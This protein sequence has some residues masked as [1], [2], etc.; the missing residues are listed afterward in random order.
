MTNEIF[1]NIKPVSC[2]ACQDKPSNVQG[3]S[4]Y[5]QGGIFLIDLNVK[6]GRQGHC[7]P[8][9]FDT[10]VFWPKLACHLSVFVVHHYNLFLNQSTLSLFYT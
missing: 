4:Y 2:L 9:L 5:K 8:W 7:L 10:V 1:C 6:T 3:H